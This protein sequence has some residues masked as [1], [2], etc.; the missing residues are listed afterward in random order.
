MIR[1]LLNYVRPSIKTLSLGAL[2]LASTI[3]IAGLVAWILSDFSDAL[4][5]AERIVSSTAMAMDT[6]AS[7]SLQAVDGVLES[8]LD[9]IDGGGIAK[10]ASQSGREKLERFVRRLPGTGAIYIVD[11]GGNVVAAVPPVSNPINFGDREWFRS[12]KDERVEPRGPAF[13]R[14]PYVGLPLRGDTGGKLFFPVAS[15]SSRSPAQFA[16]LTGPSLVPCKLASRWLTLVASSRRWMPGSEVARSG[17]RKNS[18]CIE[19]KTERSSPRFRCSLIWSA[20]S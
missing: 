20:L 5:S 11:N 9:S 16:N 17:L 13:R 7:N 12:L 15:S 4:A 14:S 2:V 3:I 6:V 19:R 10:L 8:T 18:V 1:S